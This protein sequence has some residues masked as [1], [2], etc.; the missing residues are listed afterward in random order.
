MRFAVVSIDKIRIIA[1]FQQQQ[2]RN[3]LQQIKNEDSVNHGQ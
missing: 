3:Q 1:Q 2:K